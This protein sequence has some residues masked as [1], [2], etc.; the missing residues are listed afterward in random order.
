MTERQEQHMQIALEALKTTRVPASTP[1]KVLQIVKWELLGPIGQ[2]MVRRLI[3]DPKNGFT[4]VRVGGTDEHPWHG[5]T[6]ADIK[7]Y[8]KEKAKVSKTLNKKK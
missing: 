2:E 7:R 3:Y 4:L 5:V 1:L 6:A 8:W